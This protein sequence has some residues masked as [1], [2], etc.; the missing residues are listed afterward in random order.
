MMLLLESDAPL[1]T[2]ICPWNM[3]DTILAL[4]IV[5]ITRLYSDGLAMRYVV[6][7]IFMLCY[8]VIML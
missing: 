8:Y 3:F 4:I 6:S 5:S 1:K 7:F 2:Q